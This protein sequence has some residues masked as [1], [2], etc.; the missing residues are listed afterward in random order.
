M[1]QMGKC[2]WSNSIKGFLCLFFLGAILTE[3]VLA[4]E[5]PFSAGYS[6]RA[7]GQAFHAESLEKAEA[8]ISEEEPV[9]ISPWRVSKSLSTGVE[10][11]S[12]LFTARLDPKDELIYTYGARV[13]LGRAKK[14]AKGYFDTYYDLSYENY[15]EN[16]RFNHFNHLVSTRMGYHFKKLSVSLTNVF[17]PDNS[18]PIRD[19]TELGGPTDPRVLTY[20]DDAEIHFQYVL[21]PKTS[22]SL[23]YH[24]L[25]FYFPKAS[26]TGS[27]GTTLVDS[28][29]GNT[30]AVNGL[31]YQ[32]GTVTPRFTYHWTAKTSIYA[33]HGWQK[34]DYFEGG[35]L[36]SQASLWNGGLFHQLTPKTRLN[37]EAGWRV[38]K[39]NSDGGE[40]KNL[41]L[42][43]ATS[44][45]LTP[46][47][48]V[49]LWAVRD[50]TENLTGRSESR[51]ITSV[52]DETLAESVSDLG[53]FYGLNLTW[54]VSQ[55]IT[56][57]ATASA[58][59]NTRD[60]LVTLPDADNPLISFT[61][62]REDE[63]YNWGVSL[64]WLPYANWQVFLAY[65]YINKNSSFKDFEYD[66]QEVTGSVG[67]NF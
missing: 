15:V 54:K 51:P 48:L 26:S 33:E 42:K 14:K 21:S 67:V 25:I 39:Y 52:E 49:T 10:Y 3:P 56:A 64:A 60:G 32:A 47:V 31:S 9:E 20:S 40:T 16:E 34:V 22:V 6:Q 30:A 37:A 58:G 53:H 63:Y 19:R 4:V 65:N 18:L 29:D 43:L 59:F 62:P 41:V 61:R 45:S 27:D 11:D 8:L 55:K 35:G 24:Y 17:R 57:A 28:T 23:S 38:R 50:T 2:V 46:K 36:T 7:F 12:N 13:G 66:R 5:S 44:T 1:R